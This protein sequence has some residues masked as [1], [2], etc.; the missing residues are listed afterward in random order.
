MG[1]IEIMALILA[2]VV[3]VKTVLLVASPKTWIKN[4]TK[5]CWECSTKTRNIVSL[6]LIALTLFFLLGELTIVQIFAVTL[7]VMALVMLAVASYPKETLLFEKRIFQ[8]LKAGLLA[9]VVWIAL[10]IWVLY[11]L[12]A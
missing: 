5:K 8:N 3:I 11:T 9:G 4:V 12:F 1:P 10:E 7:F 2:I 6:V